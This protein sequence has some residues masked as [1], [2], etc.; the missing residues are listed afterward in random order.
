MSQIATASSDSVDTPLLRVMFV[1]QV[2]ILIGLVVVLLQFDGIPQRVADVSPRSVDNTGE[3]YN[4]QSSVDAL[5]AKVD[6]LQATL[7]GRASPAP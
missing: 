5:S 4:L 7:S 1:L 6:A 3:I 2:A